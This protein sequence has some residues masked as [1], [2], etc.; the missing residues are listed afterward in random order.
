MF[1]D[2][3]DGVKLRCSYL[4]APKT[5]GI[6]PKSVVPI[7]LIHDWDGTRNDLA[8]FAFY[9]QNLGHAVILPDLRGHGDSVRVTGVEEPIDAAKFR[10]AEVMSAQKDIETCKK[11]LV[12]RHNLGELNIDLLCVVAVGQSSVLA[13]QWTLN[14]W[15]AFPAYNAKGTKQGQDVKALML[16]SPIKKLKGVSM[17]QNLKHVLFSGARGQA[18]PL[19]IMWGESEETSRET[20]SIYNALKKSRPDLSGVEDHNKV[21]RFGG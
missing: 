13:V 5:E 4:G 17:V 7:I 10:K 3:S 9:L 14:D 1:L 19:M 8:Q 20:E 6:D 2:T 15:V 21:C 12:K 11:F 16:I 18:L